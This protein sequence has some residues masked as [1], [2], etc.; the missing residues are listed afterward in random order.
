M[1]TLPLAIGYF[2][3]WQSRGLPLVAKAKGPAVCNSQTA[4]PFG[5]LNKSRMV[6]FPLLSYGSLFFLE[7]HSLVKQLLHILAGLLAQQ[8]GYDGGDHAGGKSGD[9]LIDTRTG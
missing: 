2:S 1:S 8:G 7:L 4:G 9:N 5:R 3:P 6:F